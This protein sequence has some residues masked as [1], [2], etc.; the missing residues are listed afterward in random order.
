MRSLLREPLVQFLFIGA[1][2]VGLSHLAA[3]PPAPPDAAARRIHIDATRIAELEA[4]A[5]S[6]W[7]RPATPEELERLIET[8]VREEA[9]AREAR[10]LGLAADDTVIR[11]RLAQ[12][13]T[14]VLE[15]PEGAISP[16]EA[17]LEAY[18]AANMERY[19][20]EPRLTLRQVFLDREKH[21]AAL[22][23]DAAAIRAAL[24]KGADPTALTDRTLLPLAITDSALANIRRIFGPDFARAVMT[25]PLG[26][27]SAPVAS[28][29]GEHLVEVEARSEPG[30]PTLD[31]VRDAV[32][33]DYLFAR[34]QE[35]VDAAIAEIVSRYEVTVDPV[36]PTDGAGQ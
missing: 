18:L 5:A 14:F 32:T 12:K 30:E 15:P 2:V 9:L 35:A 13:M 20:P 6:T 29:Y 26:E 16:D 23:D 25:L 3:R 17:A 27:W 10:T 22:A 8:T 11:Q 34:R 19:R 24:G 4:A 21:G 33:R 7:G 28:P 1:V 36:A 31:D